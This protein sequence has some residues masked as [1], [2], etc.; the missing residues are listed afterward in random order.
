MS[1]VIGIDVGGTNFRIGF[2]DESG[3]VSDFRKLPVKSILKSDD[4]LRDIADFIVTRKKTPT[5]Y[6]LR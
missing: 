3:N 1:K 6:E 5:S 2:A 4:V